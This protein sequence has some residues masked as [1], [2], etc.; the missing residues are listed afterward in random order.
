MAE[1]SIGSSRLAGRRVVITG[2]GSGIGA[3]ATALFV[4]Q[5][6]RVAILGRTRSK[7]DRVAAATG[8]IPVAG[9]VTLEGDV[10]RAVAQA[11]DQLGGIDGL[12][13][14]AGIT[15]T[16]LTEE[17][18]LADWQ[19]ML[20][21]HMT[22]TFLVCRECI[23]HLRAAG[24]ASVVNLASVAGLLPG[25]SGASY[26]AAKAGQITFSKALAAELA[27]TI[28]V[29][30]LCAGPSDTDLSRPNYEI[31]KQAGQWEAFLSKFLLHRVSDPSEIAA[32]LLFLISHES[33]YITGVA[34]AADGGRSLH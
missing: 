22:A 29:N 19:A 16:K 21:I 30:A 20:N 3:T 25:L 6:A 23:P 15:W 7:L 5:G 24:R 12:V 2:G 11:A 32:A 33:S 13:N 28:R 31:M 9:D 4:Q 1:T 8:A 27:P 17:T 34:L 14:A 26:A 18:S 10:R